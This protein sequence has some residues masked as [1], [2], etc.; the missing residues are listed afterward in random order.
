MNAPASI[1]VDDLADRIAHASASIDAAM[2]G[3]LTDVR[4]FDAIGG[5]AAQGQTSCAAWL[6]WKCGIEP[7]TAREKVRVAHALGALP[8]IDEQLRIG[9]LSYSK[10]R[11]LTRVA[12][13]ENEARLVELAKG[14]TAAQL[15][16]ICRLL[17]Q[18][19]PRD[20]AADE[21]RR[22]LR[23]RD[24]AGMVRVEAQLRPEEAAR[25][26]AACDVFA[27]SAAERAD[28]LVTM[29]EATLRGDQPQRP[30]NE[31]VIHIDA[32]T[33][34]G[35]QGDTGIPAETSRRL[36]CDAGILPAVDDA[37]GR[38]LDLGRKSRT[39]CGALRRALFVRARG[40]C[41][42]PGCAH[43]RYLHAHH[44]RHWVDGGET[45]LTNALLVCTAHHALLHEGG[46]T[47]VASAEGWRFL[48]PDKRPVISEA[49]PSPEKLGLVEK[50]PPVWDGEPVDYDEVFAYAHG[51]H[52][53]SAGAAAVVDG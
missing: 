51:G 19:Q 30:P 44:V 42:F 43:R 36:L 50:L 7:G 14:S 21:E 35:N 17:E 45:K 9:Q 46:F 22:W 6:S 47:V 5:W 31:V 2:H 11:E 48:R 13:P 49:P 25:V 24:V 1:S 26:L 16:K 32:A 41:E 27:G 23:T 39:F 38:T 18:I 8:L 12:T 29:A 4:A 40:C 20:A 10:V 15:V 53:V 33:L 37:E 52:D 28:A 3:L 34:A